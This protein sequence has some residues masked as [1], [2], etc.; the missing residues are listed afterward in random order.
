MRRCVAS[1]LLTLLICQS[2]L[3]GVIETRHCDDAATHAEHHAAAIHLEAGHDAEIHDA[4]HPHDDSTG[5]NDSCG[6]CSACVISGAL[7]RSPP[8]VTPLPPSASDH[9]PASDSS[10]LYRPPA[11]S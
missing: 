3:A 10:S 1:L 5:G 8:G 7:V 9:S 4:V 11:A 6:F 2:A